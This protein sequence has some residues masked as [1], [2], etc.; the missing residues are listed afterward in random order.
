[1]ANI[2]RWDPVR[3]MISWREA[4][5]RAM[6]EGFFRTPLAFAPW[7]EG[8]MAV[9]MYETGDSVVVKT[10]IPGIKAEEIEVSVAGDTLTIKAESKAEEE[11]KR[12]NY[13]RRERRFGSYC[14]SVAL[15]GGLQTDKAEADYCDGILTLTFP[16]AEVVKPKA[17]KVVSK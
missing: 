2:V 7:V 10:T 9:D 16:K 8:S 13:L 3:D 1:M 12:E 17:I 15:P 6:D 5:E 4:M 14:R 11:V